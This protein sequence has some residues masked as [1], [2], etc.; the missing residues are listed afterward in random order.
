MRK[1]LIDPEVE[2]MDAEVARMLTKNN[3][4]RI[5]A[6]VY[7]QCIANITV[8]AKNGL[9][10]CYVY[11]NDHNRKGCSGVDYSIGT[12][13]RKKLI[14][15]GFEVLW[16]NRD[17]EIEGHFYISWVEDDDDEDE[18]DDEELK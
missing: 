16:V 8:A 4:D 13:V 9:Q 14:E 2:S 11:F 12:A 15:K 6:E 3:F 10:T 5:C 7:S 18:E 1:N 17:T